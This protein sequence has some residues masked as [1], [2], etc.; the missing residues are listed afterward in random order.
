MSTANSYRFL[1]YLSIP[2]IFIAIT[3][4]ICIF[5]YSFTDLTQGKTSQKDLL[6]FDLEKILGRIGLAMY[7]FDGNAIV[8]NI[9][10]EAKYKKGKYPVIL[11]NAIVFTLSLFVFFASICY[12]VYREQTTPIFTM[13]LVPMDALV[14]VILTCVCINALTSYPV[15]ML[16]A[17]NIIEK[18]DIFN[19]K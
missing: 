18:F 19:R 17:F 9:R 11:K 4:M 14:M 13:G 10:A 7:I 12:Y 2:S 8:L 1:S 16:A 3:G 6:Y 15:Q 5:L